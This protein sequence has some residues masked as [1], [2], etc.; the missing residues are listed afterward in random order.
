M[1]HFWTLIKY[2]SQPDNERMLTT[3]LEGVFSVQ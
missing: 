3:W 2:S 1:E